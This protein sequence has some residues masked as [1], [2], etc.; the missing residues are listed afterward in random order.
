[1]D[2]DMDSILLLLIYAKHVM[3]RITP[4]GINNMKIKNKKT[5]I[6]NVWPSMVFMSIKVVIPFC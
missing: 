1:M 3:V 4:A 6:N 2:I 5:C